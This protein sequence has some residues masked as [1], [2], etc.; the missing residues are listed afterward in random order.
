MIGRILFVLFLVGLAQADDDIRFQL[1]HRETLR[2]PPNILAYAGQPPRIQPIRLT[3]RPP[4]VAQYP[5]Y[6][7]VY[8]SFWIDENHALADQ[9][10]IRLLSRD[11]LAWFMAQTMPAD[12]D[13]LTSMSLYLGHNSILYQRWSH[14]IMSYDMLWLTARPSPYPAGPR[15]LVW[16]C[17]EYDDLHRCVVHNV[18]VKLMYNNNRQ[19]VGETVVLSRVI[20]DWEVAQSQVPS[21]IYSTLK[22]GQLPAHSTAADRLLGVK[23]R[24]NWLIHESDVAV[25][26]AEP[27]VALGLSNDTVI[28]GRRLLW[29]TFNLFVFDSRENSWTLNMAFPGQE[30]LVTLLEISLVI[31]AIFLCFHA[32]SLYMLMMDKVIGRRGAEMADLFSPNALSFQDRVIILVSSILAVFQI[33]ISVFI[34]GS[35]A[36]TDWELGTYLWRFSWIILAVAGWHLLGGIIFF[37]INKKVESGHVRGMLHLMGHATYIKLALLGTVAALLPDSVQ[38]KYFLFMAT[39]LVLVFVIPSFAYTTFSLFASAAAHEGHHL[40]AWAG[41]V[42]FLA[43]L[44]IGAGSVVYLFRPTLY[45]HQVL[46]GPFAVW[47]M[48]TIMGLLALIIP[49]FVVFFQH[50]RGIMSYSKV[51]K[52]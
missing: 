15:S 18:T 14:A 49:T 19:A 35:G 6:P 24:D 41:L 11:I 12:G 38:S 1:R 9:T 20:L 3:W 22:F 47:C 32:T 30:V 7:P 37:G 10:Y 52:G 48:A 26:D 29:R 13:P 4:G 43:T 31:Q 21:W 50:H 34:T 40:A 27:M 23:L 44:T 17:T 16:P 5:E 46:R 42:E 28:L 39:L 8:T 51:K 25:D 2:Y 36:Y 33:T 45:Q